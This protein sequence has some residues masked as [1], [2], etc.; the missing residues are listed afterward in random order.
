MKG[1]LLI[2]MML[3]SL[4][5]MASRE[6]ILA[7]ATS[8]EACMELVQDWNNQEEVDQCLDQ[9]YSQHDDINEVIKSGNI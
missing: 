1:L 8:E 4:E 9:D 7:A 6:D 2:L 3:I 5:S